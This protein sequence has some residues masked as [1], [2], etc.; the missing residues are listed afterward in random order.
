MSIFVYPLT[1]S[2]LLEIIYDRQ[3]LMAPCEVIRL[4]D[5]EYTDLTADAADGYAWIKRCPDDFPD[6]PKD[7][8]PWPAEQFMGIPIERI[9]SP[10]Y[11][12]VGA[13]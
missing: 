11:F 12:Y 2:Q 7:A 6:I 8:E 1:I 10:D 13:R 9:E 3:Q 4:G 5:R